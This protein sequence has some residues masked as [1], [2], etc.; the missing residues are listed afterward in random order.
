[1]EYQP[2]LGYGRQRNLACS[3]CGGDWILSLDADE[4]PDQEFIDAM[5]RLKTKGD[6]EVKGYYLQYKVFFFGRF[7]R[8]G[9][10]FPERI[11]RLARRG[12]AL[13][14]EREV[15]ETLRAE[16]LIKI[17]GPGYIHHHSYRS[18]GDYLKRLDVYSSLAAKEMLAQGRKGS[19]GQAF[20]HA[21]FNFIS[22]YFLRLGFMDGFAGYLAARLESTY[23]LSKY[24]K[25]W[26]MGRKGRG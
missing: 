8:H 16:G 25:L 15:H 4:W 19:P 7:L 20:A 2:W 11:L 10:F 12:Q 17:F 21:F 9:G 3:L 13:W 26:E 14:S 6:D 5:N 24:A 1:V 18:V 22:R 23:T